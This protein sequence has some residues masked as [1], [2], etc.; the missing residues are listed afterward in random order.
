MARRGEYEPKDSRNVTGTGAT[1]DGRWTNRDG[2]PPLADGELPEPQPY[3]DMLDDEEEEGELI[4]F[5]PAPELE[6]MI[7]QARVLRRL[8]KG[9][10]TRH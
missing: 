4:A 1:P 6:Q 8:E 7:E 2:A 3:E 5:E 10:Q 9:G